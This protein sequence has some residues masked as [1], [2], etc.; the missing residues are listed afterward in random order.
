MKKFSLVLLSCML[1]VCAPSLAQVEKGKIMLSVGSTLNLPTG[2]G[3]NLLSLG[4]STSKF[5][6]E[7]AYNTFNFNLIPRVGYFLTS[8]LAAGLSL[9][10]STTSEKDPSDNSKSSSTTLGIGPFIRYYLPHKA[11]YPFVEI[12]AGFGSTK[13]KYTYGTTSSDETYN[14]SIFG[15]CAGIAVP[16]GEKASMD[17]MAGYNHVTQKEKSNGEN[18][19]YKI[20]NV[21]LNISFVFI[22][23][24]KKE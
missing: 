8:N 7:T 4:Y 9:Q 15:A 16:V 21:G 3:S 1:M 14:I 13:F 12:N 2:S 11:I 18:Y 24:G 5:S 10:L 22:L 19:S 23:G 20:G 6:G 17:I